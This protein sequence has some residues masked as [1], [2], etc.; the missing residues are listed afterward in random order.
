MMMEMQ[1]TS[2]YVRKSQISGLDKLGEGGESPGLKESSVKWPR[3]MRRRLFGEADAGYSRKV[4]PV[5]Y[6]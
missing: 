1:R 3:S 6:V 2:P 4:Q 5:N